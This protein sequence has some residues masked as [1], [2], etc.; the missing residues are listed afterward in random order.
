MPIGRH[1][2]VSPGYFETMRIPLRSGRLLNE[3]DT[4]TAPAV[5]LISE[6]MERTYWPDGK[7]LGQ[8]ITFDSGDQGWREI[9][10]VVADVKHYA[11]DGETRPEL[12]LPYTQRE[13]DSM[14]IVMRTQS[15]PEKLAGTMRS[16]LAKMDNGQPLVRVTTMEG[17]L[18]RSMAQP[19][20]Y[21]RLLA[22]FSGVALLL[23]AIGIYG[24]M[25]VAVGQKTR[26][27]GVRMA[28]GATGGAVRSMVLREGM[29]LTAAGLVVGI[30]GAWA[31]TGVLSKLLFG[32]SPT[33]PL[34]F[35]GASVLLT[36][37]A[38]AACY[39]PARRATR[40]DPLTALRC[41]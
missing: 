5:L 22:G 9:V 31:V 37:V 27:I 6:T 26:E 18:L 15:E 10:G 25:S 23:A 17:L 12:Y 24:V 40:V 4:G 7:A 38:L 8:R 36:G 14:D 1:R 16:E 33:D 29:L 41:E 3:H 11:L 35:I 34:A 13:V 2:V 32:V 20:L 30:G 39:L 28:L 21:S 19:Q